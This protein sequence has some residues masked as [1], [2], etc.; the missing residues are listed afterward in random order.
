MSSPATKTI[1]DLV[2]WEEELDP[3]N[4]TAA[5]TYLSIAHGD[6]EANLLIRQLMA[7]H[8][9]NNGVLKTRRANDILRAARRD[10]LPDSDPGVYHAR[11]KILER[12]PLAPVLVVAADKNVGLVDIA[13]GY[14]RVSAVY[15]LDPFADVRG[16][17]A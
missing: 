1:N 10:P 9:T 4:V 15:N 14:H 8:H 11:L 16:V 13:D 7:V 3:D 17:F 5:E 6:V 12:K 2:I